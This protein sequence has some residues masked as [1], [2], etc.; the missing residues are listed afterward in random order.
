M[1]PSLTENRT[2]RLSTVTA[3][4]FAQGVQSGLLFTAI[5][6]YLA[7]KGVE[8]LVIGQFI[9]L[10]F[11][12]WSFKIISAPLMDRFSFLPMGRRRPWVLAGMLGA[13]M[14]YIG[15]GLVNDPL[16]NISVLIGAGMLV[17]IST[18]FM[19]VA[20]DGMTVDIVSE[21]EY[22]TANA[23][24]TGGNIIGF[25]S[26]TA[27]AGLLLSKYGI[28]MTMLL[29]AGLVSLLALFPL[30]LRERAGER[31]LPFTQGKAAEAALQLQMKSWKEIGRKLFAVLFRRESLLLMLAILFYGTTYGLFQTYIPVLTVQELGWL[32]TDFSSLVGLSGLVAGGLAILLASPIMKRLGAFT[33]L[34]FFIVGM[35]IVGTT[36]GLLPV[37]W[38]KIWT[39]QIFVFAYYGFRTFLLIALLTLAMMMC[40][41]NVAATQFAVYMSINNLGIS[42]GS[43]MYAP[44]KTVLSFSQIFFVFAF[45]LICLLPI[46]QKV[47]SIKSESLIADNS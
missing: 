44:L 28:S 26:T 30:L 6:A 45:I 32:D 17:S 24:M 2:L 31:I 1:I 46:I 42:I 20:I 34:Q 41:K 19:D 3:M 11:L 7:M 43:A 29:T 4:Y 13:L 39:V 22:P 10:L 9:S 40:Q 16:N 23:F 36:M 33:S 18:A 38:E 21:E 8:A 47:K 25:A 5:P 35:A 12:P 37:L 15:M 14:G 27:I